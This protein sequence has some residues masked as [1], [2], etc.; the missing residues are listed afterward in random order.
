ME[1]RDKQADV[2]A[3]LFH[4]WTATTHKIR[5]I[6]PANLTLTLLKSPH[7]GIPYDLSDHA[8]PSL[9]PALSPSTYGVDGGRCGAEYGEAQPGGVPS[10][11][12]KGTKHGG[13]A[14]VTLPFPVKDGNNATNN[15]SQPPPPPIA[16]TTPPTP[17]ET[18]TPRASP[19]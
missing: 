14:T 11:Y 5:G 12:G 8:T 1:E 4:C 19:G 10:M 3:T 6:T 16:T 7:V 18:H 2:L 9:L 15:P 13:A 17:R